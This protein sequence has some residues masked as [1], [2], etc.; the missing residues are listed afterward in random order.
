VKRG[1]SALA[2]E[3][4]TGAALAIAAAAFVALGLPS[5]TQAAT[6]EAASAPLFSISKTENKNY[7]QFAERLDAACAPLGS[8]PVFAYWRMLGREPGAVEPLLPREEPAYGI[9]SQSVIDAK[10]ENGDPSVRV[11]LRAL[12]AAPLLVES[13]RGAD[14]KCEASARLPI[15]GV[16]ARL[17]NVHAVLRWPFGIARLLVSGWSLADGRAVRDTREL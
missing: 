12:P 13:W 16:E 3:P 15:A 11:A 4:V 17:F 2:F 9:A 8:A 7:V 10:G 5:V 6:T 14:G 1:R